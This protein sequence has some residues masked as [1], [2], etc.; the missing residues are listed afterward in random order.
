MTDSLLRR[1]VPYAKGVVA[2]A[3]I[4]FVIWLVPVRDQL[5]LTGTTPDQDRVLKGTIEARNGNTATFRT[6]DGET[7]AVVLKEAVGQDDDAI[8]SATFGGGE[9]PYV[10]PVTDDP[11]RQA[12][13]EE[14]I[15]TVSRTADV[16]LLFVAVLL[17]FVGSVIAVYRWSLLLDAAGL[18]I[19]FRRSFSLTFIGLFFNNVMPGLT[20]GDLVKAL[21]IARAHRNRKTEA[22]LTV[23]VDRV[24]GITGLA[25]VA[26]LVIP[27][28]W[29]E[30]AVVAPWIYGLLLVEASFALV[31]FSRRVRR[32]IKLD[33]LLARLPLQ[34]FIQKIDQAV[35]LY[36][37]RHRAVVVSLLL[38]M[39]VHL[40]IITGIGVIGVGIGLA[41]PFVS[42]F[43]IVPVGLIVMAL[44]IAPAG[45]GVGEAAFIYFWGTQGVSKA[46]ALALVLVYRMGQLLVS[47]IGGI[48]VTLEK[49]KVPSTSSEALDGNAAPE[50]RSDVS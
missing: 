25:M 21:Y 2:I 7:I 32:A 24:L 18:A 5:I 1:L 34:R 41:V 20:G 13:M 14:G 44:P 30:Y 19:G 43:A 48:C 40:L 12:R 9:P 28:R 8:A 31:F 35:F 15:L 16:S 4:A 39:V 33:A 49:G 47:L 50:Q 26:G 45:W 38:S 10:A 3:M 27:V 22:I 29:S 36:R 37:F 23:L 17:I 46:R 42:Y 11:D 6:V